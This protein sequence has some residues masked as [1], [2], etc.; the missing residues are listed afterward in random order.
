MILKLNTVAVILISALVLTTV[1][2]GGASAPD[3]GLLEA[4]QEG[5]IETVRLHME[6]GTRAD[7]VMI[8]TG[9]DNTGAAPIHVAVL[10]NNLEMLKVLVEGTASVDHKMLDDMAQSPGALTIAA[11]YGYPEIAEYLLSV[12]ADKNYWDGDLCTPLCAATIYPHM[13]DGLPPHAEDTEATMNGRQAIIAMLEAAG[14]N[15]GMYNPQT[16]EKGTEIEKG[17]ISEYKVVG[18]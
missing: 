10:N 15:M 5:D 6:A 16:L 12:G 4:V 14:G 8:P 18:G 7:D 13:E 1:A 2:C 3:K 9:F 11:W 17:A